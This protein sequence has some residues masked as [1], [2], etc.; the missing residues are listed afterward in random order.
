MAQASLKEHPLLPLAPEFPGDDASL[1]DFRISQPLEILS[2]LGRMAEQSEVLGLIDGGG[3]PCLSTLTG[4]DRGR[5]LLWLSGARDD[6]CLRHLLAAP[7]VTAVGY[8]DH[9]K[10]QFDVHN[11]Q[12]LPSTGDGRLACLLPLGLY[13]FQRRS[14]F[15]VRPA[16]NPP[17]VVQVWGGAMPH[18]MEL[19]VIDISMTGVGLRLPPGSPPIAIGGRIPRA[20]L[21]LD[22][23]TRLVADLK[24][25][26]VTPSRDSGR[27]SHMGC[28]LDGLDAQGLQ[29]LQCFIN[30]TAKLSP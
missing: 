6:A 19:A 23:R 13:R 22:A 16:Q 4:V 8:L 7:G 10:I 2:L 17:A 9:V 25:M 14:S 26:H 24:V 5:R 1:E 20:V 28:T 27:G 29:D 30:L 18:P 12:W 15:R 21:M 3:A 11:L